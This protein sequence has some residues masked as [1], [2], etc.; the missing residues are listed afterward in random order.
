MSALEELISRYRGELRRLLGRRRELDAR[1]AAKREVLSDL[2]T[3]LE[4]GAGVPAGST[5]GAPP[6]RR[7]RITQ[8]EAI[9]RVLATPE[10][11][12]TAGEIYA[13]AIEAGAGGTE[14]SLRNVLSRKVREGELRVDRKRFPQKYRAAGTG[15]G[16][17]E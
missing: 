12:L 15:G 2:R 4:S 7:G 5:T 1:I 16:E 8:A 14:R 6:P 11:S 13:A 3:A 17:A 10:T 9:R